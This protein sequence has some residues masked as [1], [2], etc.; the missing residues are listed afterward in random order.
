MSAGIDRAG[1]AAREP[2]IARAAIR[3]RDERFARTANMQ[4]RW[5]PGDP[6]ATAWHT[7]LA[8]TCPRRGGSHAREPLAFNRA[9]EAAGYDRT[10][11]DAL[12][13]RLLA[14]GHAQ[15]PI[16]WLAISMALEHF[17][18]IL[19]PE[20]LANPHHVMHAPEEI[21]RRAVAYAQGLHTTRGRGRGKRW[22][23]KAMQMLLAPSSSFAI[24]WATRSIC[25][26]RTEAAARAPA[27]CMGSRRIAGHVAAPPAALARQ[28]V[29][30]LS[31]LE[32]RRSG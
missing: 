22:N 6:A 30:D 16:A 3:V 2:A 31:S 10:A 23:I 27:P 18:A 7:A 14:A 8:A 9:A 5:L 24:A 32:P 28:L 1:P 17:A 13:Q 4:R 20:F 25:W 29:P 12:V 21:E 11:K 15:A 19:A 26:R